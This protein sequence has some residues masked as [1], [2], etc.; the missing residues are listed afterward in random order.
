MIAENTICLFRKSITSLCV[1]LSAI[2]FFPMVLHAAGEHSYAQE[3]RQYVAEDKVYL[4]ENIRQKV[5]IPSEKT[6]VEALL[7]EDGPQALSLYRKQLTQYPDP[8]LDQLSTSRIAACTQALESNAPPPKLSV[9]PPA[10]AKP[11]VSELLDSA[12]NSVK[13]LVKSPLPSPATPKP[14]KKSTGQESFTLQFGSFENRQNAET[15]AKKISSHAPVDIV[16]QGDR[17][18]VQ[19]K[20]N[21]A[22]K[23]DAAAAAKE[24][25][26]DAFVVP[27]R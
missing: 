19:L 2:L 1:A 5:T 8:L 10:A 25:P 11:H 6:V 3:I 15:L 23:N 9:A 18:K 7:S 24:L 14:V 12:K 20:Q 22:S 17:H 21:Y 26:F 4:L 16:L 27:A 13:P